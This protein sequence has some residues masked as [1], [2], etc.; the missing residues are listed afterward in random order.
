[1]KKIRILSLLTAIACLLLINVSAQRPRPVPKPAKPIIF[2]VLNDGKTVEPIVFVNKGKL[3]ETVDGGAASD[4]I[5][6]FSKT[7][8]KTGTVYRMVFGGSD[9]G[10][11]TIK[12]SNSKI[13]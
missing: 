11:V 8:Y 12:S 1:M 2:A 6:A 7:Y 10:S 5:S 4:L 13:E 3:E 9:A